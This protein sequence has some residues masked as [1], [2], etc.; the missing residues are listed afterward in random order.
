M[1]IDSLFIRSIEFEREIVE[2][3]SLTGY[4]NTPRAQAARILCSVTHEHAESLK[5]ILHAGNATSASGLMRLQIEALTRAY[6]VYFAATDNEVSKLM[7]ELTHD[8]AKRA[9]KMKML[10]QMIQELEGEVPDDIFRQ[11]SEI[12]DHSWK[13][14]SSFVHGGIHAIKRHSEGYPPQQIENLI[15]MSNSIL[16]LIAQLLLIIYGNP[17]FQGRVNRIQ[18]LYG[19]VMLAMVMG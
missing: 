14:L 3:F 19:D 16:L 11:F 10:S 7:A 17:E 5:M 15:R 12:K 8:A 18:G 6:W 13:P 2:F 4:D 1:D 9:N